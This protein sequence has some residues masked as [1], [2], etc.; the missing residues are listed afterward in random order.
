ME[1]LKGKTA[2]VTGASTGIGAAVALA[3]AA[4]GMHVAVHYNS[5]VDAAQKVVDSIRAAGGRAF[6]LRADVRDS[7]AIRDVVQQADAQLGGIDVLVNNAGSLVQRAPIAEFKDELFDEIMHINARSVLAF[8]REVVPLMRTQG[9]G[10]SIINVSSVAARNGGGPGAYL[11][12]G[13]KGFVS[14]ATRGLAK[15][16]VADQIRVNAVS[17]GVIQTPFQDR[18]STPAILESFKAGIPMGRIGTPDECVG[19]FLFLASAQMSGYMTGQI[20]EVN[21]GQYMP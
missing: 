12:A 16:L 1:D 10:G 15:E 7:A 11:Y 5:S 3:Y 17:P 13:A 19:A 9:R 4:Q 8:C 21:G 14:T 2:L 18:F 6:A 20:L